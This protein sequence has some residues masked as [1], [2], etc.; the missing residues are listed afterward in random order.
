MIYFLNNYLYD[1]NHT[2]SNVKSC[3]QSRG[4]AGPQKLASHSHSV[5]QQTPGPP[6]QLSG[7]HAWE[8]GVDGAPFTN[9]HPKGD[10][11]KNP[12]LALHPTFTV[13]WLQ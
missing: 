9:C 11:W 3:G 8:V 1:L 13:A 7:L 6:F 5:T 12:Y 4:G 10:C 2:L